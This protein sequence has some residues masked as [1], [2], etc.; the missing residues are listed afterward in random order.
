MIHHGLDPA[1]TTTP[2]RLSDHEL[3]QRRTRMRSLLSA[4]APQLDHLFQL[5]CPTGCNVLLTDADG[6][7]LEHRVGAGDAQA[8]RV[9][10]LWQGTSWAEKHEG[11]NGIGTCLFEG[12]PV[13]IHREDHFYARNTRI[14]CID[15]PIWGPD[16]RIIG[17]LDVSSARHDNSPQWNALIA[18][19]V[20]QTARMIEADL[21]RAAFPKARII[22][23]PQ[24][25]RGENPLLLAVDRDDLMIGANR[26]ARRAFGLEKEGQLRPRP[27]SDLLGRQDEATGFERAERAAVIRALARAE[28]NVSAAA[29]ALGVGRA[30]LYRRMARLGIDENP[31][32]LSRP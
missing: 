1:Q 21:F 22:V 18:A 19:Q 30:T 12:R 32:K 13:T 20:A 28:G 27:A 29:R 24:M 6:I 5:V 26:A 31:G 23:A 17:A 15:A 4:A 9:F 25:D 11:T 2:L 16:G 8:F 14:S 3:N 7:V 10:G